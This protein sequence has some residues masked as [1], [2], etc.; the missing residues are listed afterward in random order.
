MASL[1]HAWMLAAVMLL[2][3]SLAAQEPDE[4]PA[5]I[6]RLEP[7]LERLMER[8]CIPGM[9]AAL[10]QDRK[11]VWSRGFGLADLEREVW[12]KP[13]TR[14]RI[15]S[16]SKPL[17]AVL[18]LQLVEQGKLSLDTP[19]KD[20][21]IDGGSR[22]IRC[23]TSSSRSSCATSSRTRA[24]VSPARATATTGTSS[25]TSPGCSRT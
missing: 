20:F 16:V 11:L 3:P 18:T 23:A 8:Y 13:E 7:V 6:A 5:R 25:R 24:R 10:V 19:M 21:R 14:Y 22:P 4:L 15:A 1:L 17:A 9:S 2:E 12:A